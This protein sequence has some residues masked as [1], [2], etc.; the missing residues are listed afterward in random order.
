MIPL[1]AWNPPPS[2][3][4]LAPRWVLLPWHLMAAGTLLLAT[5]L[6]LAFWKIHRN[7]RRPPTPPSS[8]NLSAALAALESLPNPADADAVSSIVRSFLSTDLS[9]PALFETQEEF[10]ARDQALAAIP[11]PHR[12]NLTAFLNEL[13]RLKYL[14][15]APSPSQRQDLAA[16][17]RKLL[18]PLLPQSKA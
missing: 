13:S 18:S 15:K 5:A 9:D 4:S 12:E 14:P 11:D 7:R 17:A 8:A 1:A 2:A 6:A 16:E 3:E 10:N